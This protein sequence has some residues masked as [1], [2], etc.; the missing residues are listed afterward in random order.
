MG[1]MSYVD[2]A[3][4]PLFFCLRL[5]VVGLVV[6]E[7]YWGMVCIAFEKRGSF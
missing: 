4:I 3:L 7:I 2:S 6:G 5:F 1:K